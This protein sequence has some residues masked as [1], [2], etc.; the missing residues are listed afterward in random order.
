MDWY[1]SDFGECLS[2]LFCGGVW[3]REC[4]SLGVLLLL[5]VL[6]TL[7]LPVLLGV[8]YKYT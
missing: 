6:L 8:Q 5:F 3:G 1:L 2:N 4:I 7:L